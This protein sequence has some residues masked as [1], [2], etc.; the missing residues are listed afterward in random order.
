MAIKEKEILHKQEITGNHDQRSLILSGQLITT[1][2][3]VD[4][5]SLYQRAGLDTGYR[6]LPVAEAGQTY[7]FGNRRYVKEPGRNG[8]PHLVINVNITTLQVPEGRLAVSI[9]RPRD[10]V[11]FKL[12]DR[13]VR[14]LR[15][16]KKSKATA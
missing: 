10:R 6:V 4:G 16:Q 13:K 3:P 15:D 2:I 7:L 1:T 14:L 5:L 8:V 12:F 9:E 11:G